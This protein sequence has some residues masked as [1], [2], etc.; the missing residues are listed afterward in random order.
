MKLNVLVIILMLSEP[1]FAEKKWFSKDWKVKSLV[2]PFGCSSILKS[3]FKKDDSVQLLQN[4]YKIPSFASSCLPP[5]NANWK[6]I[7]ESKLGVY[8]AKWSRNKQALENPK[9]REQLPTLFKLSKD[10]LVWAG[11]SKCSNRHSLNLIY[12]S[13]KR[14]YILFEENSFWE[15]YK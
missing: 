13:P 3:Y 4:S 8:L 10:T 1:T 11:I 9:V 7:R 5:H 2:C 6:A 14:A 12:I 15:L